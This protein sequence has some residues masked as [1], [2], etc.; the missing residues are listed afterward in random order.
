MSWSRGP[1]GNAGVSIKGTSRIRWDYESG[2]PK[3]A[4]FDAIAVITQDNITI[5][6]PITANYRFRIKTRLRG[7][8]E[9]AQSLAKRSFG[10]HRPAQESAVQADEIRS[11][12]QG[13]VAPDAA[14]EDVISTRLDKFNPND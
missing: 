13:D 9:R 4:S 1:R 11:N 10:R 2:M 8:M 12:A 3:D 7:Y 14:R 6:M 5:R